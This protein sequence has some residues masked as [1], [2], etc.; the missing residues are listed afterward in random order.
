MTAAAETLIHRIERLKRER[1]KAR[2]L[3]EFYDQRIAEA[4][5]QLRE[6]EIGTNKGGSRK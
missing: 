5:R 1:N 3:R 2:N 4:V 6:C